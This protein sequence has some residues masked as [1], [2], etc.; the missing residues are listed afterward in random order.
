MCRSPPLNSPQFLPQEI[1]RGGWGG[2]TRNSQ[3]LRE[4]QGHGG[5]KE[6]WCVCVCVFVCLCVC[7]CVCVRVCLFV[8]ALTIISFNVTTHTH[9]CT[10]THTHTHTHTAPRKVSDMIKQQHGVHSE[11]QVLFSHG[12]CHP[13]WTQ[14]LQGTAT[15]TQRYLEGH[16]SFLSGR[17]VHNMI[18]HSASE[19]FMKGICG[20]IHI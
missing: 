2:R 6:D 20:S 8:C 7:V 10:H 19:N 18:Q 13:R 16:F 3:L 12:W 11:R 15:D 17:S 5:E 9:T 4:D 1:G 14:T